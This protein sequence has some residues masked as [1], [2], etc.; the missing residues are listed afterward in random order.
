MPAF[1]VMT[2]GSIGFMIAQ[3]GLGAYPLIVAGILALYGV[4]YAHGLAAGWI[5][6]TAQTVMILVVGFTVLILASFLKIEDRSVN[7]D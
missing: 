1:V 6:W 4:D 3:G 5:G 7:T 2:V